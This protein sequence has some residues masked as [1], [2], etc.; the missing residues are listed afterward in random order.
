MVMSRQEC[1]RLGGLIAKTTNIQKGNE[2][3]K[4]YELSPKHCKQCGNVINYINRRN[5]FCNHSC[6]ARYNNKSINRIKP[7]PNCAWC[8]KPLKNITSTLCKTGNC[9]SLYNVKQFLDGKH[10]KYIPN[11]NSIRKYYIHIRGHQCEECKNIKWLNKPIPLELH[12]EDGDANNNQSENV[13]LHCRNCHA[14]TDTFCGK[15]K[16]KSTRK[17]LYTL[18]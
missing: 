3:K 8:G 2:Y 14:F 12:H 11:K 9:Q 4:T 13:K 15:N 6:A 17:R 16:G 18:V 10:I 1:G 5:D 7:R